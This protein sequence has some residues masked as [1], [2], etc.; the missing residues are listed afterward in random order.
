MERSFGP[1][2]LL[3]TV[4]LVSF[5]KVLPLA[6]G[7]APL[8]G[9]KGTPRI[10]VDDRKTFSLRTCNFDHTLLYLSRHGAKGLRASWAV[11][12]S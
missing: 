7:N 11:T 1:V 6:L 10:L 5:S 4:L 9:T 2:V 8:S 3:R 12:R